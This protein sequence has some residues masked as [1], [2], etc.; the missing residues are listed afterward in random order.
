M[1]RMVN[2]SLN[3]YN[4]NPIEVRKQAVRKYSRS[5]V[6]W[7]GGGVATGAVFGLIAGS[8]VPFIFISLVGILVG[9]GYFNKVRKIVNHVDPQ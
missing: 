8:F 2:V 1:A 9:L 4:S 6:M 5:A 7:T 3:P